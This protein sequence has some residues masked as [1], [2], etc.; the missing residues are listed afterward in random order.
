MELLSSMKPRIAVVKRPPGEPCLLPAVSPLQAAVN[1]AAQQGE[2][3]AGFQLF[4][5]MEQDDGQG[6][7][8]NARIDHCS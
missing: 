1:Q 6:S 2:D 4:P 3:V 8:K 5:V 7:S